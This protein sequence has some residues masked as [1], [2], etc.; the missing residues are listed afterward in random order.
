MCTKKLKKRTDMKQ[1][2]QIG[3]VG[4]GAPALGGM[5]AQTAQLLTLLR[6]EG[7]GVEFL[8]SNAPL[9]SSRL[10]RVRYLRAAL[11]LLSFIKQLIHLA[12]RVKVIHLM[13]NS[14]WSW[15]LVAMPT[16]LIAKLFKC[17]VII[18]YRG[19]GAQSF[20]EKNPRWVPWWLN[21]AQHVVVPSQFLHDVFEHYHVKTTIVANILDT[22]R[23]FPKPKPPMEN[24]PKIKLIVVR[25]LEEIY[26]IEYAIDALKEI[27]AHVNAHLYIAG[28][29][30]MEATLKR[31][32]LRLGLT[33][34]VT[35]LG[36]LDRQEVVNLYHRADFALNTSLVDNMPNS[37]L[38]ALGCGVPV[39]STWV[40]GIPVMVKHEQTAWLV[41]PQDSL[42]IAQA[43][44]HLSQHPDIK[45]KLIKNGI[46]LAQHYSWAS[47]KMKWI[48]L[49]EKTCA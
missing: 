49:Y 7:V 17:P 36:R 4:P 6:K 2:I 41:P 42:A 23:F 38:E 27:R 25:H 30:P 3:L 1:R 44:I 12:Q 43:V 14:G 39:I 48:D 20:L 5:A 26:G 21:Q 19:G 11:R 15:H 35:F 29:G 46:Q 28:S 47:L 32:C 10:N 16:L 22:Q 13:A 37:I 31:Q 33:H 8:A 18:N 34:H 9:S 45:D 24:D 40:G